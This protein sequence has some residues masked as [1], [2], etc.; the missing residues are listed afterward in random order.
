MLTVVVVAEPNPEKEGIGNDESGEK[1][2]YEENIVMKR[3]GSVKR[4]KNSDTFVASLLAGVVPNPENAPNL[5]GPEV[6]FLMLGDEG[7][8]A[9]TELEGGR[10]GRPLIFRVAS[11]SAS[12]F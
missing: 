10:F 12:A 11:D 3:F 4:D 6:S 7:F 2:F 9:V 1:A 5:E 8:K